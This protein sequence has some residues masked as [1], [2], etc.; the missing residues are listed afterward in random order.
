VEDACSK[1]GVLRAKGGQEVTVTVAGLLKRMA[2][3]TNLQEPVLVS[4]PA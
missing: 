4:V 2:E 1:A 3:R